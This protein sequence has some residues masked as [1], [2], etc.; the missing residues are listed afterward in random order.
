MLKKI[1]IYIDGIHCK[2]CKTL[3][4]TEI[5]VLPGVSMVNVDHISGKT[6]ME[7]DDEK[8]NI[9]DIFAEIKKLNYTPLLPDEKEA[10]K[11]NN[12]NTDQKKDFSEFKDMALGALIPLGVAGLIGGYIL[13]QNFGGFELLAKLNEGNVS[14]GII[15][16]IGILTGFHCIGMCGGLVVAY[17]A[18]KSKK[19]SQDCNDKCNVGTRHC[20]VL[21]KESLGPHLQYNAGRFISYTLVGAILGGIGSFFAINPTFTGGLVIFSG[22]FMLLMGLSFLYDWDILEKIKLRTPQFIARSLYNQKHSKKPKAPLVI[23]LLNGFMPCGPLQAMQLY[24]LASGTMLKGATSMAIYALGTIPLMFGFGAFLSMISKNYIAKITKISGV[25]IIVLGLFMANRGLANFGYNIGNVT[26]KNNESSQQV[27]PNNNQEYQEVRMELGYYGYDPNV[28]YIKS[29]VPVRWII[30]VKQMSGCTNSIMIESLGIKKDLVKGE[31]IIEFTPPNN[32]NEIQFSC[33]MRMVWG[34]FVI[35]DND[36]K[37][38][39]ADIR[40]QA[41]ALPASGSCGGGSGGCGCGGGRS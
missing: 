23:G 2:S 40:K 5:D 7:L 29:G 15:F 28:L 19:S 18:K 41:E 10:Q 22:I 11:N 32:V 24:A 30:D 25:L 17:S 13:I 38:T 27:M 9:H 37:P 6:E 3:I 36:Y 16:I 21:T 14:Y 39:S 12:K 8:A 35:T 20:L 1:Q 4:E 33:W 31:N 26:F 34:K